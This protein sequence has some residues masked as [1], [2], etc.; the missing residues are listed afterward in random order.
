MRKH[1]VYA[2][3]TIRFIEVNFYFLLEIKTIKSLHN[4]WTGI[5]IAFLIFVGMVVSV[6][7]IIYGKKSVIVGSKANLNRKSYAL[8]SDLHDTPEN[9]Y[10]EINEI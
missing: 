9:D 5:C 10:L 2:Q 3:I 8:L 1:L 7:A 6:Y 4:A